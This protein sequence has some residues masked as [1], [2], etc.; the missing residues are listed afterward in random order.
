MS[1]YFPRALLYRLRNENPPAAS[2]RRSSELALQTP[3][4]EVL[5]RLPPLRRVADRRQP[6]H[7]SG[8]LL[9]L[10]REL[11]RYRLRDAGHRSDFVEAVHFLADLLPDTSSAPPAAPAH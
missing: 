7:E 5:L 3:G 10:R 6:P 8:P 9:P 11:Q 4:G 1:K 2:H